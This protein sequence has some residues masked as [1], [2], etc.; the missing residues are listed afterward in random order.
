MIRRHIEKSTWSNSLSF[1]LLISNLKSHQSFQTLFN[2]VAWTLK[3]KAGMTSFS[4]VKVESKFLADRIWS[5]SSDWVSLI[6]IENSSKDIALSVTVNRKTGSKEVANLLHKCGHGISNAD[7]CHLN[8][9]WA[10]KVIIST[11]QILPS[12]LSIGKSIHVAIDNSDGKQQTI[13]ETKTTHYTNGVAFQL[14]TSNFTE[15]VSTQKIEKTEC[16]VFLKDRE[17]E[18]EVTVILR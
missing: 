12:T 14:H 10:N 13:T 3:P 7:I 17:R 1:S 15:L 4:Y 11:N 8:K 9:S 5:I 16:G 18:R 6:K 2:T